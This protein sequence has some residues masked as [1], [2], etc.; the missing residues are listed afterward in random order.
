MNR[1]SDFARGEE[2]FQ[3]VD[4][5]SFQLLRYRNDSLNIIISS[6]YTQLFAHYIQNGMIVDIMAVYHI[7][8]DE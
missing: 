5:N 7:F 4:F 6:T 3:S 2:D 1:L 8:V